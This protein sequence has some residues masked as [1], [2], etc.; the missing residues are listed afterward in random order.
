VL[1]HTAFNLLNDIDLPKTEARIAEFAKQNVALI[2]TN[3]KRLE[4]EAMSQRERDDVERRAKQEKIEMLEEGERVEKEEEERVKREVLNALV[5]C[6]V[7][8]QGG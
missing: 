5:C 6:F 4:I 8:R 1:I 7:T 2:Q 3:L